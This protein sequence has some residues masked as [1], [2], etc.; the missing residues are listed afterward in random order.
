MATASRLLLALLCCAAPA[1]AGAQVFRCAD[2]AG[3]LQYSDRPCTTGRQSEV[4]IDK[5][6]EP[7]APQAKRMAADAQAHEAERAARR[8]QS[9]DSHARIDAAAAR[10]QQI[11]SENHDPRKCAESRSRMAQVVAR[12]PRLYQI[13]ADYREFAQAARLYCGD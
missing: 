2:G 10:A 5:H 13:S 11:R 7:V 6:P 1:I 4:K 3:K 9:N 12:D 8:Q